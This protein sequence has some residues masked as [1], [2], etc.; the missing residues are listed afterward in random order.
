MTEVELQK[1]LALD[2]KMS[3]MSWVHAAAAT[4]EMKRAA[5]QMARQLIA[6]HE[7]LDAFPN[8][9]ITDLSRFYNAVKAA[10]GR[11]K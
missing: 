11:D 1:V 3:R 10:L 6:I 7:A 2:E 4:E 9:D 5:V 8:G